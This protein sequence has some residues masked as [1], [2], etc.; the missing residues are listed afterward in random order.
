MITIRQATESDLAEIN[1]IY[2]ESVVNSTASYDLEPQPIEVRQEWFRQHNNRFAVFVAEDATDN[3]S[4][5]EAWASLSRF[6]PR[7]GYDATAE[8]SIYV[9]ERS[10]RKGI[11]AKLQAALIAHAKANGFHAL[12][13]LTTSEN[14][15]S[16]RMHEQFGFR[17]A[18]T[19]R[20]VGYKFD[21]W[22]DVTIMQLIL[23]D[24]A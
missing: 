6:S 1:E 4:H 16:I 24:V 10:W 5:I 22:L 11:G 2:N 13:A 12:L 19:M 14:V 15:G 23:D 21:Q 20:E 9:R 17:V 8:T 18:G 7:G 3:G